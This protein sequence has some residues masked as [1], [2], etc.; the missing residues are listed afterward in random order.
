[1]LDVRDRVHDFEHSLPG[2]E[3]AARPV[4]EPAELLHRRL[5]LGQVGDEQ[6]E[7]ARRHRTADH[8]LPRHVI[9]QDGADRRE[10]QDHREED[11]PSRLRLVSEVGEALDTAG[12]ACD[13]AVLAM[14]RFDDANSGKH[15]IERAADAGPCVP[16]A[17]PNPHDAAAENADQIE[18][19]RD[20]QQYPRRYLPVGGKQND[21]NAD[22]D[23]SVSQKE[24]DAVYEHFIKRAGVVGHS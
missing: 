18:N 24:W 4:D 10:E 7:F 13:F 14:E 6:E 8:A 11:R 16:K 15:A 22:E 1:M 23:Q 5:H 17:T 12:E 3:R 20:R 19:D 9:G 21:G 2:G